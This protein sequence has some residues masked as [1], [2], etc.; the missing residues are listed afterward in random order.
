ME[1]IQNQLSYE[2]HVLKTDVAIQIT[3]FAM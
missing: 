2:D 1:S 3:V